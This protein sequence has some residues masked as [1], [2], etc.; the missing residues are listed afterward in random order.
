M[1][2]RDKKSPAIAGD[3][4]TKYLNDGPGRPGRADQAWRAIR[5]LRG[6]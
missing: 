2:L 6:D 4:D 3:G 1:L 5:A